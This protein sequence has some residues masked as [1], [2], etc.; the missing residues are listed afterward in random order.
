MI[1]KFKLFE[2]PDYSHS[3]DGSP[4]NFEDYDAYAF[5]YDPK[6]KMLVSK[7]RDTHTDLGYTNTG[8][9]GS[10]YYMFDSEDMKYRGRLWLESKVMSFWDYPTTKKIFNK[11]LEDLQEAFNAKHPGGLNFTEDEWYIECGG[12]MLLQDFLLLDDIEVEDNDEEWQ[13]HLKKAKAK[14]DGN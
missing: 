8:V 4:L 11:I 10:P 9:G 14:R 7:A 13:E 2:N 3:I 6:G 5:G 12:T 1:T